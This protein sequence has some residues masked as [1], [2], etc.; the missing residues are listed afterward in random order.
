VVASEVAGGAIVSVLADGV[1]SVVMVEVEVEVSIVVL[2]EVAAGVSSA[3]SSSFLQPA[4]G[5]SSRASRHRSE[6]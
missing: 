6:R 5:T 1:V 4:K 3:G 2:S